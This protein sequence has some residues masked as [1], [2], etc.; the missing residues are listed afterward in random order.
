MGFFAY[1]GC[2]YRLPTAGSP[3][4][5]LP[6]RSDIPELDQP[7]PPGAPPQRLHLGGDHSWDMVVDLM[8][9]V[10]A[11]EPVP[12]NLEAGD[13]TNPT[14]NGDREPGIYPAWACRR[15]AAG[16]DRAMGFP[17]R[18]PPDPED[19]DPPCLDAETR[20]AYRWSGF[21]WLCEGFF[22]RD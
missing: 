22:L 20:A 17:P 14:R 8:R 21:L 11:R 2:S 18:L 16:I 15:L 9:H 3:A 10:L 1:P 6:D 5:V 7:A 13:W 4:F 19:P 12:V